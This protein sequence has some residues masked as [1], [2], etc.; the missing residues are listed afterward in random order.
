MLC[1]LRWPGSEEGDAPARNAPQKPCLKF[2]DSARLWFLEPT[3][4]G[5][6]NGE[7]CI[8]NTGGNARRL[9]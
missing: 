9:N 2:L 7:G 8:Q 4:L 3:L 5:E 1:R 6:E